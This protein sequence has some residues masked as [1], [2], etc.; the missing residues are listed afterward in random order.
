MSSFKATIHELVLQ[1]LPLCLSKAVHT[2]TYVRM[3]KMCTYS[4]AKCFSNFSLKH[5]CEQHL[6]ELSMHLQDRVVNSHIFST[7]WKNYW[8]NTYKK[9]SGM[10]HKLEGLWAKLRKQLVSYSEFLGATMYHIMWFWATC[11]CNVINQ[12]VLCNC[13][14]NPSLM[15]FAHFL[16]LWWPWTTWWQG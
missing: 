5:L 16:F 12:C 2:C 9:V 4:F 14:R 15:S 13:R 7:F 11:T 8:W 6:Y 10:I 1:S 3:Y